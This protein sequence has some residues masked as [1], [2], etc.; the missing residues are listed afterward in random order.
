LLGDLRINFVPAC[1]NTQAGCLKEGIKN[2][3]DG[4]KSLELTREEMSLLLSEVK[5]RMRIYRAELMYYS[6]SSETKELYKNTVKT[7]NSIKGRMERALR[8]VPIH[9][10][11][12][13]PA[14]RPLQGVKLVNGVPESVS[15]PDFESLTDIED[16]KWG[17]L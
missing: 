6:G 3:L 9:N 16:T 7:L 2:M 14:Y 15:T 8:I 5:V 11:P 1:V 4:K 12:E 13:Y 17:A 10:W